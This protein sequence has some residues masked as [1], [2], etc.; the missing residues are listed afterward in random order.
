MLI[1]LVIISVTLAVIVP[2][3][4]RTTGHMKLTQESLNLQAAILFARDRAGMTNRSV[5]LVIDRKKNQY[6]LEEISKA[7]ANEFKPLEGSLGMNRTLDKSV[8]I[9]E[10]DQLTDENDRQTL[11]FDPNEVWPTASITL[12]D[13]QASATVVLNGISVE[14][15]ET[16]IEDTKDKTPG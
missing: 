14:I 8:A 16:T 7:D 6:R 13:K 9:L 1:V 2:Y 11:T 10:T 5:R 12:G 3:S 4:G 15:N